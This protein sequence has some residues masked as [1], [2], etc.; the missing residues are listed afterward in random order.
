M[1]GSRCLLFQLPGCLHPP[2][3]LVHVD[4]GSLRPVAVAPEQVPSVDG[5]CCVQISLTRSSSRATSNGSAP[6]ASSLGKP[7]L[8]RGRAAHSG[9]FLR[10]QSPAEWGAPS[11][12]PHVRTL[13]KFGELKRIKL[14]PNRVANQSLA[15]FDTT[16]S[17]SLWHSRAP[18]LDSH[19]STRDL[20]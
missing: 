13:L 14:M 9:A 15:A 18:R 5:L 16:S 19:M 11:R 3:A 7:P 6:G 8:G 12:T 17:M 10:M 2:Q 4:A 1:C 20:A